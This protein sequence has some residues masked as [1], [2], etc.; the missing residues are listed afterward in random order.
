MKT[1]VLD[2]DPTGTQCATG[3]LVLLRVDEELLFEALKKYSSI[4]IQTNSRALDEETAISLANEI[5][6]KVLSVARKL[7]EEVTFILRGD[8]T[9]RGHVFSE[10]SVFTDDGAP[11]LFLPSYPD[12]GR[13][14]VDG[15]HY[16][17]IGNEIFR[18]DQTEFAKDPVFGF[19]TSTLVNY[20][21]EKTDCPPLRIPL[22]LVRQGIDSVYEFLSSAEKDSVILPDAQTN[23]DIAI[24]GEA[25]NRC[26]SQGH[27][28]VVRSA[29]PLAAMLAGVLSE[30][31]LPTPLQE[32][33]FKVLL[34][35]GSHTDGAT[36][37]LELV[38][39]IWGSPT[40]IDTELALTNPM[41][42]GDHAVPLLLQTLQSHQL[43]TITTER[44]R[45]EEHNT[46][47]HGELIMSALIQSVREVAPSVDVVVAKGGIT[48][49]EV[50]RS[51]LGADSAWVMGQIRPGISVWELR[52][53]SGRATLFVVVPGNV[54]D[55]DTLVEVLRIVGLR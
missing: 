27:K 48:S 14:T 47:H 22:S 21:R 42:A 43:A 1:V 30:D 20:V 25:V 53:Q 17:K 2:D 40:V 3:V 10:T 33:N 11:I 37:Q 24:I 26:I 18:A 19:S 34:V 7:G 44:H 41:L 54:G 28:L 45:R 8:S 12:V 4:Y 5:K 6:E 49:A 15:E 46:L 35:A 39:K 13:T 38:A 16:V 52:A 32:G 9:L 50:A 55:P 51:G 31:Y 36:R 23:E 29:A